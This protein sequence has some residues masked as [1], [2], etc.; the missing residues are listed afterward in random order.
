MNIFYFNCRLCSS[1]KKPVRSAGKFALLLFLLIVN[2]PGL[3]AQVSQTLYF[4]DRL[5]Q[6]SLIN[7]AFQHQ[8]NFH[9]GL[10]G[11]SSFNM[12]ARTNFVSFSDI[13]FK[14][15]QNDSLISFLHPDADISDFTSKLRKMNSVSP[16]LYLNILSF[17][18]RANSSF[19]SFNISERASIRAGLPRD[20][21][22][23]GLKG[24]EQFM[25]IEADLSGFGADLS[26]FR[27]YAAGYSYRVNER[28][29]LGG[30]A[31]LLFGKAGLY[32][33]D[34]DMSL[35]TDPDSYNPRLRSRFN[36]NFSMP[37][38][39]VKNEDGDIEEVISHFDTDG[40][41][42]LDFIFNTR[43]TGFAADLGVTYN[44]SRPVTLFA[45]VTD[46]GFINWKE[47]VYN[48]SVD[49]DFE[50]DGINLSPLF[51]N[52]DSDPLDNLL[53]SLKGIFNLNDTQN[54]FNRRLP[55]RV[56]L[57]GSYELTP[58]LSLGLL[59][60]SE[61]YNGRLD[62]AFTLSAN[63]NIGRWLSASLSWSL[64]NNSY[65]NLGMGL[66]LRGGGFQLY[67]MSDNLNTAFF[68]H[69][70]RSVN[71][72]FGLN[73]VFGHKRPKVAVTDEPFVVPPRHTVPEDLPEEEKPVVEPVV[74]PEIIEEPEEA[75]PVPDPVVEPVVEPEIAEEPEVAEPVARPEIVREPVPYY[76][77]IAASMPDMRRARVQAEILKQRGYESGVVFS[78]PDRYRVYIHVGENRDE[79]VR[80]LER[81]R[82]SGEIPDAWLLRQVEV[83]TEE[84]PEP[85]APVV[86]PEAV[87]EPVPQFYI[88]AASLRNMRHA[89]E[90]AEILRQKGYKADVLYSEPNR[91]RV[92][93]HALENRSDALEMLENVRSRGNIPDAWLLRQ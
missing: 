6:S 73:L 11:I 79:A 32:L 88:I 20:L 16:D 80:T 92:Y 61:I 27:E 19:F 77:I 7:P 4:M 76:Y 62:Q 72:W 24:N 38:T 51:N 86:V 50:F 85:A 74:E 70:A 82:S 93:V 5:P 31:K 91:Y 48:F 34:T 90:Q 49:G 78:E 55:P 84:E 29:S 1:P 36:M 60:R 28:L 71:L 53:D 37:V 69:R 8:H 58:G 10:P 65:N 89:T 75:E 42:P 33:T 22:L 26:Y 14:H 39:L 68:P 44:I 66:A 46:L 21:I 15:P 18:F 67:A 12:N 63:S 52:D 3:Q 35:F 17:G 45:S 9:I 25:G 59:S 54:S 30:R 41:D 87:P 2:M 83:R 43:N 56:Y 23:L 13:F 40:Y 57:G 81:V 47:D 64:M